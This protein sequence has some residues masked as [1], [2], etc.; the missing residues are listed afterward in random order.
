MNAPKMRSDEQSAQQLRPT[1]IT[2]NFL[3]HAEGSVLIEMGY[4]TNPDQEKQLVGDGFQ[5]AL[6]QGL[7]DAV[8]KFRDAMGGSR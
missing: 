4:L 1:T 2:P 7:V 3:M 8:M 6:V 5:N